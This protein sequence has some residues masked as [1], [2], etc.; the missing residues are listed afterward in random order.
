MALSRL[1]LAHLSRGMALALLGGMPAI[2]GA[3][4]APPLN[5]G[6][7]SHEGGLPDELEHR[8]SDNLAFIVV[9]GLK[10][11]TE[12]C[13]ETLYQQRRGWF[14]ASEHSVIISL[15]ASDWLTCGN[16]NPLHEVRE[17]LFDGDFSLG[18][19]KLPLTRQAANRKFR[20][21]VEN[22]RWELHGV[23]FATINLPAGN[24]HYRVD[25]GRNGEFEDRQIANRLWL[26]RLF[27]L[28]QQ[29]K[30][31]SM[32]LFSDGNLWQPRAKTKRDGFSEVR[33]Q[34]T[35]LSS[36]MHGK[37][38]LID[39]QPEQP[40]RNIVWH[41]NVGHISLGEGWHEFRATQNQ[42]QPFSTVDTP[43]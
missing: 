15:A 35:Q 17:H 41:G 12:A 26:Q 6:V 39:N 11:D 25:A 3:V 7:L 8:A 40:N 38:L 28:A 30:L 2:C 9:N 33:N 36:K 34:I 1:R 20:R 13:N 24:N 27:A 23:L 5:F 21:Y 31:R 43:P 16:T 19:S 14:D 10:T 37:L 4:A 18:V 42:A 32:V 22:A 29:K